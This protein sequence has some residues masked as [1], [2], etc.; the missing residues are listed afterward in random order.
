MHVEKRTLI[1]FLGIFIIFQACQKTSLEDVEIITKERDIPNETALNIEFIFSD[2]GIVKAKIESPLMELYRGEKP[3]TEMK[4]GLKATFY[5]ADGNTNAFLTAKYGKRFSTEKLIELKDSVV[6]V[7]V[8]GDTLKTQE[9]FWDERK[10]KVYSKRAV[11]VK[12]DD[13]IIYSNG[14][15]SDPT[16]SYYKFY[17]ITGTISLAESN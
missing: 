4:N 15:E 2:S 3:F 6:V 11:R 10:D 17:K 8:K 1:F 14:F 13:E 9:L 16:F 12:T 5:D 7:N